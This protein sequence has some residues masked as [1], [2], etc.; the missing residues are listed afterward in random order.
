MMTTRLRR[1]AGVPMMPTEG[2]LAEPQFASVY[3]HL[4]KPTLH[5]DE[6]RQSPLKC[7]QFSRKRTFL[8]TLG[9]SEKFEK[10]NRSSPKLPETVECKP[11]EFDSKSRIVSVVVVDLPVCILVFKPINRLTTDNLTIR[12]ELVNSLKPRKV[13]NQRLNVKTSLS[14]NNSSLPSTALLFNT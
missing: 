8:L 11:D 6:I 13:A 4:W 2:D 14:R 7:S 3:V 5:L 9:E 1:S 10:Q 12:I